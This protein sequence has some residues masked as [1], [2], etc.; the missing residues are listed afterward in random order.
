[1]SWSTAISSR[2][3]ACGL[4]KGWLR[5]S[6][7]WSRISRWSGVSAV[8]FRRCV[9]KAPQ[10][11]GGRGLALA[12]TVRPSRLLDGLGVARWLWIG[13]GLRRVGPGRVQAAFVL[14]E[15]A[16]GDER[17]GRAEDG[18]CGGGALLHAVEGE[19]EFGGRLAELQATVVDQAQKIALAGTQA[20]ERR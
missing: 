19:V 3:R 2:R 8:S 10:L 13:H 17:A 6:S 9:A 4:G 5:S 16:G 11:C 18:A 14:S 1:M 20:V 15:H 7:W 12:I